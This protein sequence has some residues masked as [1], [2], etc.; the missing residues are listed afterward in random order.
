MRAITADALC[1]ADSVNRWLRS[2]K[3][4]RLL[5]PLNCLIAAVYGWPPNVLGATPMQTICRFH[6]FAADTFGLAGI[7]ARHA[8]LMVVCYLYRVA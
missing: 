6:P 8:I 1:H 3:S 2:A 4:G 5:F 7:I